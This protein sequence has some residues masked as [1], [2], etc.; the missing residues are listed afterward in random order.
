MRTWLG[1]L[2]ARGA[3]SSGGIY[4]GVHLIETQT[5]AQQIRRS[6]SAESEYTEGAAHTMEVRI[7]L[8]E[9]GICEAGSSDGR[10]MAAS[11]R[12]RRRHLG[13]CLLWLREQGGDEARIR[14]KPWE[15]NETD[16]GTEKVDLKRMTKSTPLWPPGGRS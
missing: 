8:V 9:K 11:G 16:L 15:Q 14:A 13:A 3:T 4:I 10:D 2:E 6:L 12:G 7:R 5:S 1:K